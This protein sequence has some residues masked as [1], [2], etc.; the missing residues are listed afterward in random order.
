MEYLYSISTVLSYTFL[1]LLF[2]RVLINKK[3]INFKSNKIEWQV[4]ASLITLSIVPMM[5][6]FLTV[7]IIYI[8]ILMKHD[9]FIK[10]MNNEF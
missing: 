8:S 6:T 1:V 7:S 9:D 10:L 3:S 2:I 5:N 4:L